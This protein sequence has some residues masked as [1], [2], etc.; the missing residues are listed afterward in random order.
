ME[1]Q[2]Q[3]ITIY[4]FIYLIIKKLFLVGNKMLWIFIR[5][6]IYYFVKFLNKIFKLKEID[7]SRERANFNKQEAL[8]T[9]KHEFIFDKSEEFIYQWIYFKELISDL[10]LDDDEK[11][12]LID[13][14]LAMLA[15]AEREAFNTTYNYMINK[16]LKE[17]SFEDMIIQGIFKENKEIEPRA[18][19]D[20][21]YT[22]KRSTE[23]MLKR[24]K[25][26]E[27]EW[28]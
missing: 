3:K 9:I 16:N 2:V 10:E 24:R 20:N 21:P 12:E 8:T 17:P 14:M 23:L 27:K 5:M 1:K 7:I 6:T 28:H 26:K 4:R 22:K 15:E 13:R 18:K 25:K 19:L 11:E